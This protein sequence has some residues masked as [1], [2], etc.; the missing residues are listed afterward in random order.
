MEAEPV[1]IALDEGAELPNRLHE[2]E[3]LLHQ[4][5]NT[6]KFNIVLDMEKINL[7]PTKFIVSLIVATSQARRMGGDIKLINLKPLTRNNLVTFSPRTYLSIE[8][9]E[10]YALQDF[11]ETFV[12]YA[13]FD[14]SDNIVSK[15]LISKAE[16]DTDVKHDIEQDEPP[17]SANPVLELITIAQDRIRIYSKAENLY[18]ICDFVLDKAEKAGFDIRERGKIKVTIYEAG[19]NVVEHAYFSNPDNWIDVHAGYDEKKLVIIIQDWGESFEFDPSRP[20][21]VEQAVKDRRTGGFGLHIIRRSVD[22]IRYLSDPEDGNRLILV[23]Y[24]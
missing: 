14:I 13:E 8:T 19:L 1:Y 5:F 17:T 16:T 23:K 15:G 3:K 18:D 7:P 12:S 6:N 11:G 21:D 2:F 24:L 10:R 4:Y 22:E 20:Y 9:S